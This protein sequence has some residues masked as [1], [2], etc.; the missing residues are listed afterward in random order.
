VKTLK[1]DRCEEEFSLFWKKI[2]E[3]KSAFPAGKE[4]AATQNV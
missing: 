4:S 3:K 2:E 1:K